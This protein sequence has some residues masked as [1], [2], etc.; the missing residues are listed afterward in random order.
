MADSENN[1]NNSFEWVSNKPVWTIGVLIFS[2]LLVCLMA[3]MR[4]EQWTPL[5]RY[6]LK[7]YVW[8]ESTNNRFIHSRLLLI[9]D[10]HGFTYWPRNEDVQPGQTRVEA[11][12]IIPLVPSESAESA[13]QHLFLSK[14]GKRPIEPVKE[15]LERDVYAGQSLTDLVK[16]V[17][18]YPLAFGLLFLIAGL[19]YTV[20]KDRQR[21][22]ERREGR[23]TRGTELVTVRQFVQR[24]N[25]DGIGFIALR[26]RNII[27]TLKGRTRQ[28]L[29]R[30]PRHMESYHIALSGDPG[31]GKS[32]L[33]MG[34]LMQIRDRGEIAIV[35]DAA[36][37][38]LPRFYDPERG[39][40]IFN[41]ADERMFYWPVAEEIEDEAEAQTISAA[42]FPDK[43][44]RENPFFTNTSQRIFAHLLSYTPRPTVEELI[45]WLCDEEVLQKALQQ[46]Q[47]AST[48]YEDAGPQRG[49]VLSSITKAVDSLKLLPTLNEGRPK[50][51]IR[52]WAKKPR[53]WIFITCPAM[54]RQ[55]LKPL[56]SMFLDMLILRLINDGRPGPVPVWFL[57][58]EL[59][60]LEMLPQLHT[61]LTQQRKTRNPIVYAFQGADQVKDIYGEKAPVMLSAGTRLFMHTKE[62]SAAEW[63]SRC[64]GDYQSVR[65]EENRSADGDR[66]TRTERIQR[67][68]E[69]TVM[70][71]EIMGMKSLEAYL[72]YE[73][74]TVKFRFPYFNLA[75]QHPAFIRRKMQ[76]VLERPPVL[77]GKA[78]PRGL[79][80][81]DK[82]PALPPPASRKDDLIF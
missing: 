15:Y 64:I 5:E 48:L 59:A 75:E 79:P 57:L 38:F 80:S 24:V 17:T 31:G 36:G 19:F 28:A 6:W 27:D 35:H 43:D 62:E 68:T 4:Y 73:I 53:G 71:S 9:E 63:V 22:L 45:R 58:D 77:S 2:A 25:G 33:S 32:S 7:Q 34:I 10:V 72:K 51:T 76:H 30:I 67:E 49:A 42:L 65:M 20:P 13:G 39:D 29:L 52:Q 61:A 21:L 14:P 23:R 55:S 40:I 16:D 70:A 56:I 18:Y 81:K 69:R 47:L 12:L 37:E 41:P 54:Y 11:G 26:P 50:W 74:L 8:C 60:T 44:R 3:W 82:P 78:E 66:D 1:A 46:T